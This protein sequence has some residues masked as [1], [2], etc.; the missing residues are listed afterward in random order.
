MLNRFIS[1]KIFFGFLIIASCLVLTIP[2]LI[3]AQEVAPTPVVSSSEVKK[4]DNLWD[5][6]IN[7]LFGVSNDLQTANKSLLPAQIGNDFNDKDEEN[8]FSSSEEISLE[9]ENF[10][11]KE[12]EQ[13]TSNIDNNSIGKTAHQ[14]G[15]G[16]SICTT[17]KIYSSFQKFLNLIIDILG[18]GNQKAKDYIDCSLPTLNQFPDESGKKGST[19]NLSR[20]KADVLGIFDR[21]IDMSNS[22]EARRLA[23]QPPAIAL[24]ID[25]SKAQP[26]P[27]PTS[28]PFSGCIGSNCPFGTGYCSVS[29]LKRYFDDELKAQRASIIC[30]KESGSNPFAKNY[31]CLAENKKTHTQEYSVGLFQI[32]LWWDSRCSRPYTL[33]NKTTSPPF[34]CDKGPNFDYCTNEFEDPEHNINFAH[35]MSGGGKDWSDW[36]SARVCA[37]TDSQTN[38]CL[39]QEI[40]GC[41]PAAEAIRFTNTDFQLLNYQGGCIKPKMIVLHWSGA[42]TNAQ[43][44][45]NTL[46]ERQLACQLATDN[47]VQLQMQQLYPSVAQKG[48]CVGGYDQDGV[49]YNTYIINNEITGY[50]F[51]RV[52]EDPLKYKEQYDML[53]IETEKALQSTCWLMKQ[54]QIPISQIKGHFQLNSDKSDPGR[55]YLNE[56]ISK[57]SARSCF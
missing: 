16:S 38:Q 19:E 2:H 6:F 40:A 11:L 20:Q 22:L 41:P 24:G 21:G 35:R 53:M 23:Y 28:L 12:K 5:Q 50:D 18:F 55:K 51:D 48:Q 8:I 36:S 9:N 57:L 47:N 32:N 14:Y 27:L 39:P 15:V 46:N 26:T 45:F 42:W 29:N 33:I 34:M 52:L 31:G 44:T 13:K 54:Y 10:V 25:I 56:F 49:F 1:A 7:K 17:E 30:Q 4:Q 43:A 3:F 37:I